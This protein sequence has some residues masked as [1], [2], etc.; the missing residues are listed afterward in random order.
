M[1]FGVGAPEPG[2][3]PSPTVP[4]MEEAALSSLSH[5]LACPSHPQGHPG[6]EGPTGEKG[7]QV[8]DW[9]EAEEGLGV[10]P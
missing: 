5:L 2:G 9:K 8:S 10:G 6:H 3:D 7:A 1:G 4:G